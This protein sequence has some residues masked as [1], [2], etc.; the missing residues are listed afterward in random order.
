MD[1]DVVLKSHDCPYIVHCLGCFITEAE[2]WICMELMATCF[3][4]LTKNKPVPEPILGKITVAVSLFTLVIVRQNSSNR[5]EVTSRRNH[6]SFCHCDGDFRFFFLFCL[7]L[8]NATCSQSW[9]LTFF[10]FIYLQTVKALSYL[11]T[12]HDV[13]HRDVKPSNILIDERG[14]IKLCDFGI[15]GRL[16]DSKAKTRSAGCAAYMA[17]SVYLHFSFVYFLVLRSTRHVYLA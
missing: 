15:S 9:S 13:I 14:N 3:E 4:K 5:N 17:V 16:V 8:K 2:V 12:N 6:I 11:K 10:R 7:Q 1:I